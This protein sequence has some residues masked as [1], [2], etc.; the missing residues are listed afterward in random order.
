LGRGSRHGLGRLRFGNIKTGLVYADDVC[1]VESTGTYKPYIID[2]DHPISTR[3][4]AL[5]AV[6]Q[7]M[8]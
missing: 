7:G 8:P 3:A 1:K 5:P 2:T 4:Q 6:P